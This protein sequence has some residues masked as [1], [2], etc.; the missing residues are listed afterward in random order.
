MISSTTKTLGIDSKAFQQFLKDV[1]L[2]TN[3]L[4]EE[5]EEEDDTDID[6]YGRLL[7]VAESKPMLK[8]TSVPKLFR[9]LLEEAGV[10]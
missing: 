9:T 2:M 8:E 3:A 1:R 4:D 7:S 6:A 5:E 10:R